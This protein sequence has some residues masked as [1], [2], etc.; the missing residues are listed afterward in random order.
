MDSKHFRASPGDISDT[1]RMC[2][3]SSHAQPHCTHPGGSRGARGCL[4]DVCDFITRGLVVVVV[5]AVIVIVVIGV[6]R[7]G[8]RGGLAY[9]NL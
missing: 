3:M 2:V 9:A 6:K 5:V 8:Y 1:S 7:L 4:L